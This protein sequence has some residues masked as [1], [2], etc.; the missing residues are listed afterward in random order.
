MAK[1]KDELPEARG[2][3]VKY[4]FHLL[5]FSNASCS[6]GSS[7]MAATI[8]SGVLGFGLASDKFSSPV[9]CPWKG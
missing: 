5:S 3:G 6:L 9:G 2:A 1:I 7:L 8:S 4:V